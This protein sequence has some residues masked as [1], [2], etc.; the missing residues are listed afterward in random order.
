MDVG[1]LIGSTFT[2]FPEGRN[3]DAGLDRSYLRRL[4]RLNRVKMEVARDMCENAKLQYQEIRHLWRLATQKRRPGAAYVFR[5]RLSNLET[6][7][8]LLQRYL[9]I[10]SRDG[11]AMQAQM[12]GSVP[13]VY[14]LALRETER[15]VV[16]RAPNVHNHFL[17]EECYEDA[18]G[19]DGV[20]EDIEGSDVEAERAS[21]QLSEYPTDTRDRLRVPGIVPAVRASNQ[22]WRN[23]EEMEAPRT[24]NANA[25]G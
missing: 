12:R 19:S 23:A 11:L 5:I 3:D 14:C 10:L 20:D 2:T 24:A 9:L 15:V 1:D 7:L 6:H 4:I 21:S 22:P 8:H 13:A 18:A 16:S 17:W 25:S